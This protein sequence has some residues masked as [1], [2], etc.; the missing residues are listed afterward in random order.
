MSVDHRLV[1]RDEIPP[2]RAVGVVA[3]PRQQAESGF[4]RHGDPD[5]GRA[6]K[7]VLASL[8]VAGGRTLH[9]AGK[10]IGRGATSAAVSGERRVGSDVSAEY[11]SVSA[12]NARQIKL[13]ASPPGT[14]E[15]DGSA[16]PPWPQGSTGFRSWSAIPAGSAFGWGGCSGGVAALTP[17]YHL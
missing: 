1:D 15:G 4:D 13:L 16:A 3:D 9:A 11:E 2:C 8:H 14:S 5:D 6:E 7:F 12:L 10:K 17:G